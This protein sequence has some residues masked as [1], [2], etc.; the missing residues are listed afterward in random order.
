VLRILKLRPRP[1][2]NTR[3]TFI[4]V[5]EQSIEELEATITARKEAEQAAYQAQQDAI[6]AELAPYVECAASE[7]EDHRKLKKRYAGFLDGVPAGIP[8]V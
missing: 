1:F 5:A 2:Y 8:T 7:I 6:R 4:S 3:H